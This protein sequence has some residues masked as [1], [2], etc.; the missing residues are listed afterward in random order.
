MYKEIKFV[1]AIQTIYPREH[2][3][4]QHLLYEIADV[5]EEQLSD[6]N[7]LMERGKTT[8]ILLLSIITMTGFGL[9]ILS[10][11]KLLYMRI[12]YALAIIVYL[13]V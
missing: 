3:L 13:F 10:I 4:Y 6:L 2:S 1:A 8:D 5:L 11:P 12:A 9:F 7:Y